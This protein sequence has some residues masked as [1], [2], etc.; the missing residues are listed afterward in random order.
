VSVTVV[1]VVVGG[2]TVVLE[3][4]VVDFVF[5][6]VVALAV[7]ADGAFVDGPFDV[8][9][10]AV[11]VDVG[12]GAFAALLPLPPPWTFG[13]GDDFGPDTWVEPPPDVAFTGCVLGPPPL[14]RPCRASAGE[15]ANKQTE[16][17]NA[18]AER[19]GTFIILA[20]PELARK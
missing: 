5:V 11:V 14:P 19:F 9:A 3:A 4:V 1:V 7:V 16:T 8:L 13:A 17:T 2:A 6:F 15:A 20:P 18:S 10:D 12:F